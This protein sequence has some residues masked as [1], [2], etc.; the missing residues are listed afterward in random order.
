MRELAVRLPRSVGL[1]HRVHRRGLAFVAAAVAAERVG[2]AGQ[3][4]RAAGSC[5]A[6]HLHALVAHQL[7]EHHVGDADALRRHLL[8][9]LLIEHRREGRAVVRVE[10]AV[11]GVASRMLFS[12]ICVKTASNC[13][14]ATFSPCLRRRLRLR[15]QASKPC[16]SS[17]KRLDRL[18]MSPLVSVD[19][20]ALLAIPLAFDS[21]LS[22]LDDFQ[23]GAQRARRFHRL[24]DRDQVRRRRAERVE[25]LHDVGEIR[26]RRTAA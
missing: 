5:G 21:W 17:A 10:R 22:S 13:L 6:A 16:T 8:R 7:L 19:A 14:A 26:A 3:S 2:H 25:R 11:R 12:I 4:A 24:Q 23:V 18:P 20:S 9:Q 15:A 1:R